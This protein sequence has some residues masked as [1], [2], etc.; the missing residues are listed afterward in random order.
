MVRKHTEL[1]VYQRAFAAAMQV[2]EL[3]KAF[4]KEETYLRLIRSGAL[5]GPFVPTLVRH[6]GNGSMKLIS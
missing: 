2:F 1:E 6:G 5:R 3:S 4:P